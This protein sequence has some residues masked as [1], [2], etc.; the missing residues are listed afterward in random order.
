MNN[1]FIY[2]TLAILVTSLVRTINT[3][4]K[5]RKENSPRKP[6]WLFSV[7]TLLIFILMLSGALYFSLSH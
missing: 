1:I 4:L 2:I 3:G 5:S 6:L 7:A